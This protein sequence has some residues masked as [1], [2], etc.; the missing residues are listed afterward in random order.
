MNKNIF[1]L[2]ISF[3]MLFN[4]SLFS[5]QAGRIYLS[6]ATTG[7]VYDITND[8]LVNPST[9]P[10]ALPSPVAIPDESAT[11]TRA[12][13]LAIGYDAVA[14]NSNLTFFYSNNAAGSQLYKGNNVTVAGSTNTVQIGGIGT[15]NVIGPYFGYTYGF[16]S[17]VKR[18]YRVNPTP[19]DLGLISGDTDWTNGTAF[20]TD[21]FYDYQN[22]I[23]TFINNSAG[24]IRYLY[25]I[26][27]ANL[28]ATKVVQLVNNTSPTTTEGIQGMAYLNNTAFIANISTPS[29]GNSRVT[30]RSIN[31]TSGAITTLAIYD[32]VGNAANI[33]LASV[34]YFQPFTFTCGS[35]AFQ[36]TGNYVAG[37]PSTRVLRIPIGNIYTPGT[38]TINVNGTGFI[39]PA[40]SATIGASDTFIDV[41]VTY[42]GTNGGTVP[43][44]IDL[45]GSTTTCTVN[46]TV[47][48]DS[49]ADGIS[50]STEGLCAQ[51]GFEGFDSPA[52]TTVNGNNIQTNVTNYN[53][54]QVNLESAQAS[55]FNIVRVNGAGYSSGPIYANTG[56]QYL[57]IN[58][59]GGTLY[60]DFTL[61]S[62]SVLNASAFFSP[63]ELTGT[64]TFNTSIQVVRTSDGA[65]L[66]SG[67]QVSFSASSPKDTWLG[68][69]L[70]NVSLPAGTY[71]IQMYI[72]NNGHVDS[73]TYCFATD[74]DGDGIADYLDLDSDND[75]ILDAIEGATDTDTDGTPN[76]RDTDSDN[77]GCPDVIEG[78]ANFQNGASYI[79]GNRLNTTVNSNGVPAVPTGV[80]P[81]ITNYTQAG[82][83]AIGTSQNTTL[84]DV[85]CAS[86]FGCTNALYLSQTA[87]LYNVGT[88][89]N[90]FT[91]PPVGTASSNYNAIGLNP[92]DG[93][94]YGM[95]VTNSANLLVI[96]PNGTSIN[97][98]PVTGLPTG[99]TFNAGEIDNLGNYYVKVNTDNAEL[100]RINLSTMTATLITLSASVNLPDIAFRTTNGFLYGINSTNGQLVSINLATATPTG[101]VTGI[102]ITPGA[103]NF[104]AMFASSTGE[105]YGVNNAG[106]FYQFNLVDGQRVLIS[107]AP[108]SSANDGAHCVTTPIAFSADLAITKTDNTTTY[109]P[110]TTTTYTI[111]AS[112]NGPFG[113]LGAT[114]S[115]PLPTGISAANVSYTAVVAGG[116]VTS[117]SGT[118]TGAINDVI[119]LPVNGT[120]TYTVTVSVPL[121][122]TGNLV[123]T[124]T[125]TAPANSTDSNTANNTAT[126]TDTQAVCYRPGI[127][128]GTV[129]D[130]NH[131]ITSLARAGS[132]APGN[133]PMVRKGAWTAL[134]SRT[135]GFVVN[136]LTT[137]E[138]TQIPAA[139][140]VEGMMVY[141]VTLDCL[142]I[143]TTGSPAGWACFNTPTCPSN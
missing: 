8:I 126:D 40:Y 23:Y 98:G 143:N 2:A 58:A 11:P 17:G 140:L 69:S 84:Q 139:N 54:W 46:A 61:S 124:V 134:E 141:N 102:G 93:R 31:M 119:N 30:V 64:T 24:T 28:T 29:T 85:Q 122:F 97:L 81:A 72:H 137:Q 12:S 22:N 44:T 36:G 50:N 47:I 90:P 63:R 106:G 78:A 101:T 66:F 51:G 7:R 91:Y 21:A 48:S 77:D 109:T 71:R 59:T 99:V 65:V 19:L 26:S 128:G 94:I 25:K 89:T 105:M 95:Q 110:G 45:N 132:T 129:L 4:I 57:D 73:I 76:F 32:F 35:I 37:T 13:N 62:P 127:T 114:V 1:L 53:G 131:G 75:G 133:W 123:N 115:D 136:R 135:K 92:V 96:N 43:L 38:Y 116:A 10:R 107:N 67:N 100:Y 34:D 33:D 113:V 120:V 82:G 18:L 68:S 6:S 70:T 88:A 125:I 83:Q 108:A 27:I 87:T 14:G 5:Q 74:T 39:N 117:V 20:G 55:P 42:N 118:Q 41:P 138:I 16:E 112:N 121:T 9:N 3:V 111:V 104:G 142:Q 56:N 86:A 130:T 49:D 80:T 79:T 60:R 52:Q 103:V 15:N